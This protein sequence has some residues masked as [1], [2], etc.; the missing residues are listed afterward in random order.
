MIC[1]ASSRAAREGGFTLV[2]LIVVMIVI[3]VMAALAIPRFVGSDAFESRGFTD[4]LV[5][6]LQFARQQAVAQRRTVCLTVTA[7]AVTMT[8]SLV[9]GGACATPVLDP[10]S[11]VA[12]NLPVPNS[13]VVTPAVITFNASGTPLAGA[14]ITVTGDILRTITVEA[15]TG[16][17]H[18]P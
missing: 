12:Y 13:V 7:A 11:G 4:Q 10:S 14:A 17:A 16:Y 15:N 5:S 6:T 2:E 18:Q 8:R 9:F 1:V 3:G